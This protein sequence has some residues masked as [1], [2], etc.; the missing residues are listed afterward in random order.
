MAYAISSMPASRA[1]R[2]SKVT[3]RLHPAA[4]AEAG[5]QA[6]CEIRVAYAIEPQG[7]ADRIVLPNDNI[8]AGKQHIEYLR[9]SILLDPVY[10]GHHPN[11]F[12]YRS[13][14]HPSRFRRRQG[15]DQVDRETGLLGL[16]LYEIPNEN[17]RVQTNHA[18]SSFW[19][20]EIAWPM[21][22]R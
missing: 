21:P 6:I 8:P 19:G 18:A 1:A 3:V 22:A 2:R 20:P 17:V 15:V 7:F 11:Q 10:A 16:V 13:L 9:D 5:D 14:P 12:Q 4:L